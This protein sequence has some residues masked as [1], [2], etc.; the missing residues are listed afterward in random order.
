[1]FEGKGCFHFLIQQ[2]GEALLTFEEK[3]QGRVIKGVNHGVIT[4]KSVLGK[5]Y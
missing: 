4:E 1:M 3:Y 5:R 2:P